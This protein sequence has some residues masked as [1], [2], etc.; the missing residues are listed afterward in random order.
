MPLV[1]LLPGDIGHEV[2]KL[3]DGDHLLGANIDWAVEIRPRQAD[4]ALKTFVDVEERARLRAVAPD[5]DLAIV[6]SLR[7]LAAHRG[8]G[9]LLAAFPGALGAENIVIARYAVSHAVIA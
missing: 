6:R 3:V 1:E 2:D 5:L 8:R 7:H 4:R 9:L